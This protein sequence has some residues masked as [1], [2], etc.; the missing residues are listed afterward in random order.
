[1]RREEFSVGRLIRSGSTNGAVTV[2]ETDENGK[3]VLCKCAT[4]S[5]PS[6]AAGYAV[7][8]L[9]V[10]T[11]TGKL[12]QNDSVTSCTFNS[13]GDIT[14][15]EIAANAI[16]PIKLGVR[17]VVALADAAAA[18]TIAQ[19][20]TSSIFTMTPTTARTFTT[21]IAATMVAGVTGATVG[22]WFDFTIVN[23]AA[24]AITVT[25]GDGNVTISGN[26][27]VNKGSAT[28]RAVLGATTVILYRMASGSTAADMALAN[29]KIMIGG[30]GGLAAEQT[31]SGVVSM[32]N[33]GVF[34][35]TAA[36]SPF[37]NT[38]ADPGTGQAIPVTAS[39]V[40]A[41]T[42]AAAETNTLAAPSAIGLLL[43]ITCDVYA[44]G[45]RVI[46]CA[47]TVNQTGNNTLTLG[48]AGDTI[49]LYS[50]QIGGALRWRIAGND[51]VALS[52]V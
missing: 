3:V 8:C 24:F 38:I 19:L 22:S 43:A 44:V 35:L 17:T 20:M 16:T 11:T 32:T 14:S 15:A 52:T 29:G 40:C 23:L 7:G 51:G 42:T 45:D 18:P 28:F 25:A 5:I 30:A 50:T 41:I 36:A 4:G 12:Y 9:L 26:A 21:P 10:D 39:G 48:A 37:A 1:M 6:A 46:T 49:L 34:S 33:A 31:P 13:I 47:T 2:L 27:V